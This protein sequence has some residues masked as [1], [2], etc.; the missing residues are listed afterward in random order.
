MPPLVITRSDHD[1]APSA[2]PSVTLIAEPEASSAALLTIPQVKIEIV[3]LVAEQA[4]AAEAGIDSSNGEEVSGDGNL[5]ASL[6]DLCWV[7]YAQDRSPKQAASQ[8]CP[9]SRP[10]LPDDALLDQI[11][12]RAML[13]FWQQADPTTG[14]V[15]DRANNFGAEGY[16]V[17]SIAATG[18]GLAGLAIGES[19]GWLTYDEAYER[20][21]ATLRYLRDDMPQEHGFYY[22]FVDASTGQRVWESEV[23]SIDTAWLLAGVLMAGEY[24]KD[25]EV[26]AIADELY[27]RV[28][29]PWMLTDGGGRPDEQL[30][31]H[32]W[33]PENG[34][35][36]Y[37]WDS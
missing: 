26:E 1:S 33:T 11:Q 7:A 24:F 29:F 32:G 14:L 17:A 12:Q 5:A 9:N 8:V 25:T 21:L 20:T 18:F 27:G 35:L 36:P 6:G 30:L 10:D 22:H 31:S 2:P 3:P 15:K 28:D 16:K 34:F 19:H 13:Y 4:A 23:S 37:R